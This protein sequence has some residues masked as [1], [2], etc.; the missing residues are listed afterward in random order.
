MKEEIRNVSGTV[1]LLSRF[2]LILIFVHRLLGLKSLSELPR[3]PAF[4]TEGG[5]WAQKGLC[6][7]GA[8]GKPLRK[9]RLLRISPSY[10]RCNCR[11]HWGCVEAHSAGHRKVCAAPDVPCSQ[12]QNTWTAWLKADNT[13]ER[14]FHVII[15]YMR[16][17]LFLVSAKIHCWVSAIVSFLF[18]ALPAFPFCACWFL[19]CDLSLCKVLEISAQGATVPLCAGFVSLVWELALQGLQGWYSTIFN[20][21]RSITGAF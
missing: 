8:Y 17:I 5:F 16:K 11:N 12:H 15:S 4:P 9:A 6:W 10:C 3:S 21:C 20:G 14:R 13:C 7:E 19:P 18:N 2:L 1:K